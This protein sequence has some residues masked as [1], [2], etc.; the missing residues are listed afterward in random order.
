MEEASGLR[1]EI[2]GRHADLW[3]LARPERGPG[4]DKD[5]AARFLEAVREVGGSSELRTLAL[6]SEGVDRDVFLAGADLESYEPPHGRRGPGALLAPM[7]EALDALEALPIPVIA[8]LDG[9]VYGGGCDVALAADLRI[10]VARVHFSFSM[11]RFGLSTPWGGATRLVRLIGANRAFLLLATGR[12]LTAVEAGAL[13]L[14]DIVVPDESSL[15]EKL[16]EFRAG[17]EMIG[18]GAVRAA[19]ETVRAAATLPLR[20]SLDNEYRAFA[21]LWGSSEHR[22]GIGAYIEHRGPEW[23]RDE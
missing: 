21:S 16:A 10:A 4:V 18:P 14:V 12:P 19:K 8:A 17:I 3:F 2:R 15:D 13:G 7:R 9:S 23:A 1:L 6:R 22:E 11:G 5:V 20:E